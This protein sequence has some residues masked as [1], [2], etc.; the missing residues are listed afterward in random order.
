MFKVMSTPKIQ[1]ET[2]MNC[3]GLFQVEDICDDLS[4]ILIYT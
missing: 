4:A 1:Q 3:F 2:K